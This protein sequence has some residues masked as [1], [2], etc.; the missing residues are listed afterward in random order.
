MPVSD[1]RIGAYFLVT[2]LAVSGQFALAGDSQTHL[3]G[4]EETPPV[5]TQASAVATIRV[6][7]DRTISGTVKTT[8]IVGTMAHVH[9]GAIGQSGP[10]IITLVKTSDGVWSVPQGRKLTEDQYRAYKAGEL[11]V[12]VHSAEHPSGE[13]RAQLKP[14]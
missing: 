2:I 3:T 10:P 13:I 14:E 7:A 11:Y 1:L 5:T 8:G 12:N 9:T 4:D 6:Y